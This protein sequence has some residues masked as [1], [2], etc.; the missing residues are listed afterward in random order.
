MRMVVN[1]S[2]LEDK[3][4]MASKAV[5]RKTIKPVLAGFLI[6]VGDEA[7]VYATDM[8]TAVKASISA[9]E[10]EGEGRFVIEASTFLEIVKSLPSDTVELRLD[11]SNLVVA[12]GRSRF[13][14][15]TMDPSEFPDIMTVETDRYVELDTSIL[16]EMMDKVMFAAATDEFMRNLN[17]VYWELMGDTLRLV[18][19]DGFRLAL[20]DQEV[21]LGM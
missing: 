21:D 8:E 10:I 3:L 19:S 4:L 18:A 17:G 1:Q 7:V 13:N 2:E 6:E 16:D 15:P 11:G 20:V 9:D 14:L 12:S 5:A